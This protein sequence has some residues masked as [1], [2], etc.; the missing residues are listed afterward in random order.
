MKLSLRR[1]G[2]EKRHNRRLA[3][4]LPVGM[5][6][7][8]KRLSFPPRRPQFQGTL[9]EASMYGLQVVAPR[10]LPVGTVLKLWIRIGSEPEART[11]KLRGDVVWSRPGGP[12]EASSVGIRLRD[13]P[14][15][16]ASI[17]A[18]YIVEHLRRIE[19]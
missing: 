18:N 12:S 3:L 13:R 8:P 10:A 6:V 19:P 14:R 16:Y 5:A 4:A 11:I 7:L 2:D 1:T 17:W 15:K 9:R